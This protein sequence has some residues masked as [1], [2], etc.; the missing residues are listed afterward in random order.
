MGVLPLMIRKPDLYKQAIKLRKQGYS[1]SEI[2]EFISVSQSTIS[3]WCY[4]VSLTKR[5]ERR[6]IEK[7]R[8]NPFI[9][10]LIKK[11]Q[12]EEIKAQEWAY[13]KSKSIFINQN[14]LFLVGIILYWAE[15]SQFKKHRAIEFTNTD[16]N[17]IKIIMFV[18]RNIFDLSEERFKLTVRISNK[19]NLEEAKQFWLNI[20]E[21]SRINL[22]SPELLTLK[23]T[24][25][26]LRRHPYGIC[27]ISINNSFLFK[28]INACSNEIIKKLLYYCK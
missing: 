18:F 28:K 23:K 20:T 2:L 22:R 21:L 13:Q 16:P 12:K 1:Y 4:A 19:G 3:R 7:R 6:L 9:R 24:S 5:Q 10:G 17:M 15:G 25:Q 27:R 8:H 11:A 26:S 14:L